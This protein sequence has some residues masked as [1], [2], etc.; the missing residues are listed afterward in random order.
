MNANHNG[1]R[2]NNQ[3]RIIMANAP[4]R[5]IVVGIFEDTTRAQKA[6]E[7]LR[8]AGFWEDQVGVIARHYESAGAVTTAETGSK[9]EEGAVTGAI[10]GAGVGG[11]WALGIAAGMLPAIG[12]VIAGGLL[13]SVLASAAGGAAVAGLV[14]A[15]I[16][17]GVPEEEAQYYEGEFKS[18][19]TLVTVKADGRAEEARAILRR[20]GAYDVVKREA[21]A[22]LASTGDY[23]VPTGRGERSSE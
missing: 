9:W 12:P 23:E 18:G 17:L 1:V 11:L 19:K 2:P 15:L 7:E 14:G 20:N 16:G 22:S 3:G 21:D 5:S 13:A 6:V 10:A 4:I 8:R